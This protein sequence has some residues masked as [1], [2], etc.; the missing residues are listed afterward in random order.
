MT[1][2]TLPRLPRILALAVAPLPLTPVSLALTALTRQMAT[3]HPGMLRRL[4]DYAQ[5]RF[6]LDLTDLPFLLLLEPGLPRPSVTAHRRRKP[7]EHDSRIAGLASVFLTMMH[8][9]RDGDAL[10][11]SGDLVIEGDTSAALALRNAID[12]AELDLTAEVAS[13]SRVL[14]PFLTRAMPLAERLSG[15]S[16]HRSDSATGDFA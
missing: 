11:F 14:A 10:F 5:R 8:G 16:L 13:L 2:Q 12:D 1:E 6:L 9:D 15:L 3:R 4:G 7:P